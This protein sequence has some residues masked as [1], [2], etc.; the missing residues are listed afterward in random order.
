MVKPG[1][2]ACL[3]VSGMVHVDEDGERRRRVADG[4]VD[5]HDRPVGTQ[6]PGRAAAL[7][8]RRFVLRTSQASEIDVLAFH[9]LNL[10]GIL[11]RAQRV[12]R[13]LR[14]FARAQVLAGR[15]ARERCFRVRYPHSMRSRQEPGRPRRRR[16]SRDARLLFPANVDALGVADGGEQHVHERLRCAGGLENAHRGAVDEIVRRRQCPLPRAHR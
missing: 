15:L 4:V 2:A 5:V 1:T 13:N 12:F 11:R 8:D 6:G 10:D 7:H 16:L 3:H 14:E 9:A